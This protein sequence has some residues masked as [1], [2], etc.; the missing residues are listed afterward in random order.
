MAD[1][2]KHIAETPPTPPTRKWTKDSGVTQRSA[3]RAR[4]ARCPIDSEV[5]TIILQ[6][7]STYILQVG[8]RAAELPA[9]DLEPNDD[10]ATATDAGSG[11]YQV[12]G[13]FIGD[14]PLAGIDV[15]VYIAIRRMPVDAA[16]AARPT[17]L[18]FGEQYLKGRKVAKVHVSI[19]GYIRAPAAWEYRCVRAFETGGA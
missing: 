13:E 12:T 3:K 14:G 19:P 11:P 17:E 4:L 5:E 10:F 7:L 1:V 6:A 15:D 9:S 16:A 2:L 8:L 18:L